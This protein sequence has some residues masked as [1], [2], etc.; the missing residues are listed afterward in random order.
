MLSEVLAK[1][2]GHSRPLGGAQPGDAQPRQGA[3][4]RGTVT[5]R[6]WLSGTQ[7][8]VTPSLSSFEGI[9]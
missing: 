2:G 5:G 3:I 4:P 9:C 1:G 6:S 8:Q 7:R